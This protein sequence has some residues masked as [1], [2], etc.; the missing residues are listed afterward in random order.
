MAYN[1]THTVN[2]IILINFKIYFVGPKFLTQSSSKSNVEE[3][4]EESA[5]D[6][7]KIGSLYIRPPGSA[8]LDPTTPK[9]KRTTSM[10]LQE[11][12]TDEVLEAAEQFQPKKKSIFNRCTFSG[13]RYGPEFVL[14]VA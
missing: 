6:M 12:P 2:L 13:P 14:K 9:R 10:P 8:T 4:I 7:S 11:D 5:L 3:K 1:G